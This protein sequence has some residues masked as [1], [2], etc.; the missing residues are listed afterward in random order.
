MSRLPPLFALLIGVASL[1]HADPPS[2]PAHDDL[3]YYV[4]ADG[5]RNAVQNAN[6]WQR[7]RAHISAGMQDVMGPL[8]WRIAS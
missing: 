2:Y 8:H 7:R 6:D 4:A 3:S 1:A 5:S